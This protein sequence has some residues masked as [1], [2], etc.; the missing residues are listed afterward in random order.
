MNNAIGINDLLITPFYLALFYGLAYAVRGRVTN[1]YTRRYFIPALTL[2]FIGA[3][4]LGL[5]YTYYYGI[6]DTI[7]YYNHASI[8]YHA[9]GDSF[10]IGWKLLTSDLHY[11]PTLAPYTSRMYWFT[12][13]SNEFFVIRVAT[14]CALLNFNTYMVTALT[15]ALISFSGVWAM[16]VTFAKLR[17]V[18]YHKL[19]V[20]IFFIPSVFFWGSG[21]LKDSL[22][23][24]AI[25]WIFYA[26][27][28]GAIEKKNVIRCLIIGIVASTPIIYTKIY[29]L[30]AFIPPALLWVFNE[31]SSRIKNPL[32]RII[33]KPFFISAGGAMAFF[34]V[35][36]LT[37][38]DERFD[39]DNI[40]ERSK[41]T[42]EALYKVSMEQGGSGY[43]LGELDGSIGSIIRLG[44]QA[45]VVTLFRPFLWEAHNPVMLLSAIE[46]LYVLIF[47]ITIF[48]KT[49][50]FRTITIITTNPILTLCFVF[51]LVFA[52]AVGTSTSNFGTLVRYKLPLIPFFICGLLITQN[53]ATDNK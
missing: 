15:F 50:F 5:V 6:G 19:A 3:V 11:D 34:A 49:G 14:V 18:I 33:A 13:G 25:G 10:E 45:I 41:I 32:L 21:L 36:H 35:T 46:S 16:Y 8:I 30:L 43:H 27:Y 48:Y 44:P 12:P 37:A 9:F 1:M 29:I 24:G 23:L 51:S 28:R 47:T 42:S 38:G 40:G 7:G 52:V 31:N 53:I 39:I 20:A 22:C 4:S 17:P 26:F 2:K